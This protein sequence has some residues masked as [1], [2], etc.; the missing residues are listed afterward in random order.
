ML[1]SL[2]EERIKK[3]VSSSYSCDLLKWLNVMKNYE[4]GSY[5]YHT[6]M[7]TD[8][9]KRF[10]DIMKET[11]EYGF[12]KVKDE[13]QELGDK[14]RDMLSKKGFKSVAA[15]GFEAPGVIVSYTDD[16]DIHSGEKFTKI[17]FQVA[18]GVP[19]KC[20]EPKD[21]QTFRLGLFGLDKLNNPKRTIENLEKALIQIL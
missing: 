16:K 6:T 2:A 13:Q 19:L 7:P 11:E 14:V 18:A 9:L 4:K 5:A 21:Y 12:E 3:T 15:S 20:D 17:G 10:R 8:S 1:S